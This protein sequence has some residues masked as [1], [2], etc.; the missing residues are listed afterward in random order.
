MYMIQLLSE[1]CDVVSPEIPL[2]K[3]GQRDEEYKNFLGILDW[4]IRNMPAL[5]AG[6][7]GA[8][9]PL[10]LELY[11]LALLVYLNWTSS[12]LLNQAARTQHHV[13]R[14]FAILTQL[15]TCNHQLP[16][17]ILGCEA[18]S[19]G[20]RAVILDLID[21]TERGNGSRSFNCARVLL[22][23][24]WAQDDLAVGDL[25][26]WDKLSFV[27]SCCTIIPTFV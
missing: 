3:S 16:V 8:E 23:A 22:Q 12:D 25:N 26:Y 9:D 1:I 10:F 2:T 21:R 5:L 19:D 17:F 13:D 7:A 15:E 11:R 24:I 4:R 6:E 14:A 20:Q 27:I 18:R